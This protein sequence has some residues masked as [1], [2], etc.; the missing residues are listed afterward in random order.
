MKSAE[1]LCIEHFLNG[2]L[3]R[4]LSEKTDIHI[5]P[6]VFSEMPSRCNVAIIEHIIGATGKF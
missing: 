3:D 1:S 5:I 2:I 6:Y 4:M